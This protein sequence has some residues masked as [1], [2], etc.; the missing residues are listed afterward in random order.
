MG[1]NLLNFVNRKKY[2]VAQ[3]PRKLR[4]KCDDSLS[5]SC[6]QSLY[7]L[8]LIVKSASE[9]ILLIMVTAMK[10]KPYPVEILF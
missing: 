8:P 2:L 7:K 6:A 1:W 3:I 5:L 10:I 4:N 9:T